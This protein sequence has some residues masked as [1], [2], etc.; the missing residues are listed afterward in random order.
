ME[1][2]PVRMEVTDDLRRSRLTVLFR[3]LLAIPHIIWVLLWSVA[4][5]VAAVVNWF[6]TLITGQSP[7][8]LHA[9]L[10]AYVRYVTHFYAYLFLAANPYPGFTGDPNS[11]PIDVALDPPARQR[12]WV[13]GFR[14]FLALPALILAGTLF[15]SISGGGGG[16]TGGAGGEGSDDLAFFL[17]S[18]GVAYIVAFLAW[19]ACLAR[20]RMPS[21]F[22]DL[23][24]YALRY[25]AEVLAYVLVLTD[26]YPNSDPD[27]P[28]TAHPA[29]SHPIA[30]EVDDDLRRSR[31]TVFFRLLLAFPHLVWLVLWTVAVIAVTIV[32]WF[33]T[34]VAGRSPEA[35]HRFVS[36]FVRYDVHVFAFLCLVAN[37]F[38]G[39]TGE[40]GTYPVDLAIEPRARQNRWIT[41]FRGLLAIPA[42]MV[43]FALD[44]AL[45]VAAFLGWF[46]SLATGRMPRGLRNLEAFVLRYSA[47]LNGYL[48]L[49]T[50]RY[51]Y[52]GPLP[53]AEE[54]PEPAV[55]LAEGF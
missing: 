29:P 50:D 18:G 51:P 19:F 22:R 54:E 23:V 45:F 43:T 33:I 37:P 53:A 7:Q 26:R 6:A 32:N 28:R 13:T 39:F 47:Q 8:G 27:E 10:S 3:L 17:G 5:V 15:G 49:L 16:G 30:M 42:V 4:A 34:L 11:Y 14:I 41:G 35:F 24:A 21:G 25:N 20:G 12:R 31:L 36:A 52:S 9:F 48:Y 38:P 1:P 55:A 40:R 46:A 2:H 44:A